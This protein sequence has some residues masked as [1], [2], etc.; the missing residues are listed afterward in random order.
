MG[1]RG[2]LLGLLLGGFCSGAFARGPRQASKTHQKLHGALGAPRPTVLSV[3]AA[4]TTTALHRICT[5]MGVAAT[6]FSAV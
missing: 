2:L 4:R 3:R 1:F 5:M 6:N